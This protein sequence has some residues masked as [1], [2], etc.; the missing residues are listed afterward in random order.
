MTDW[1]EAI[2]AAAPAAAEQAARAMLAVRSELAS[3]SVVPVRASREFG[4]AADPRE[5]SQT[6]VFNQPVRSPDEV[7]RLMRMQERYGLAACV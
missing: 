4:A 5:I 3:A 6:F 7:A 1:A 2:G